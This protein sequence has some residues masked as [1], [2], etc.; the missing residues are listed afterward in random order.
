MDDQQAASAAHARTQAKVTATLQALF[1]LV[2][3]GDLDKAIDYCIASDEPWRAASLEG[4]R[5]W[6]G[7]GAS[8][9]KAGGE[10]HAEC[11]L[12]TG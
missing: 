8:R 5:P 12:C 3:R 1:L 2:R 10:R 11:A 9:G 6:I 4:R 7:D